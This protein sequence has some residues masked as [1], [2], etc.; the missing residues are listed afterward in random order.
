MASNATACTVEG[1]IS[2]GSVFNGNQSF[3]AGGDINIAGP[4]HNKCLEDLYSAYCDP[5]ILKK[6]LAHHAGLVEGSFSWIFQN[7]KFKSWLAGGNHQI[8]RLTAGP[9]KGKTMTMIG[10]INYLENKIKTTDRQ[11]VSYFLCQGADARLRDPTEIMKAFLH[12]IL[13]KAANKELR[14]HLREPYNQRG[15][16]MFEAGNTHAHI[17]L[18]DILVNIIKDSNACAQQSY[19]LIDGLDECKDFDILLALIKKTVMASNKVYWLVVSRPTVPIERFFNDLDQRDDRQL[20]IKFEDYILEIDRGISTYISRNVAD[21]RD[22]YD[23]E[24]RDCISDFLN[25]KAHGTFLWVDFACKA[26]KSRLATR[27]DELEKIPTDL[28][29]IYEK[30]L[31]ELEKDGDWKI[32]VLIL[33]TIMVALRPLR[34]EEI[35]A[36]IGSDPAVST[37]SLRPEFIGDLVRC[38]PFLTIRD[39]SIYFIHYTAKE[40][41]EN[42]QTTS[43]ELVYETRHNQ[44]YQSCLKIFRDDLAKVLTNISGKESISYLEY[45]CCKWIGHL[46]EYLKLAGKSTL[47][48]EILNFLDRDFINWAAALGTLGRVKN[49]MAQLKELK[50]FTL[51]DTSAKVLTWPTTKS[52]EIV[53]SEALRFLIN[54][55]SLLRSSPLH[56]YSAI[57]FSPQ[58]GKIRTRYTSMIPSW[59]VRK[60]IAIG[61][62]WDQFIDP[63][64]LVRVGLGDEALGMRQTVLSHNAETV[65]VWLDW[66]ELPKEYSRHGIQIWNVSSGARTTAACWT[67][68]QFPLQAASTEFRIQ[69]LSFTE[70][71][72]K[73][74]VAFRYAGHASTSTSYYIDYFSYFD[75]AAREWEGWLKSLS[76]LTQGCDYDTFMTRHWKRDSRSVGWCEHEN[77][78]RVYNS[79]VVSPCGKHSA[80]VESKDIVFFGIGQ[81]SWGPSRA[82]VPN[83]RSPRGDIVDMVFSSDGDFFAT[84]A[85]S[86]DHDGL[87]WIW[88]DFN[89]PGQFF[90]EA[91]VDPRIKTIDIFL[92][93]WRVFGHIGFI[94]GHGETEL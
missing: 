64:S 66:S 53:V 2:G 29:E 56:V 87:E 37:I 16:K 61:R 45:P 14:R 39:G 13:R 71:N 36:L 78:G 80:R 4:N 41:F 92:A 48:E 82:E 15:S 90:A 55:E 60:P 20:T 31:G 34:L 81:I 47:D 50:K 10:I 85:I 91:P 26:L 83:V 63:F 5:Y 58:K 89:I 79:L 12:Q 52:P 19:F 44:I 73:L 68:I 57:L 88:N 21:L 46:L 9:G 67:R 8:L 94:F 11:D 54:F 28:T 65:A 22:R 72:K 75:I 17:F 6:S 76:F 3:Q 84:I 24:Y 27:L 70:D 59:V 23:Q 77:Q 33:D 18:E 38:N 35:I 69:S 93:R 86:E 62:D 40:Y 32:M 30:T 7:E 49:G 25:K 74:A 51:L 43:R 1:N 42:N